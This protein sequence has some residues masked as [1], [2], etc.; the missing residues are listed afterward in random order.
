VRTIWILAWA[1][2]AALGTTTCK[3][4]E[5]ANAMA[6]AELITDLTDSLP[7]GIHVRDAVSVLEERELTHRIYSPNRCEVYA[8][9]SANPDASAG[10]VC[11]FGQ[12]PVGQPV[13][14][15]QTFVAYRLFFSTGERLVDRSIRVMDIDPN[16]GRILRRYPPR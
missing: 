10:G 1:A 13:H 7:I 12:D 16:H 2:L 5:N 4:I 3:S 15:V 6:A 14:H 9:E 8:A 11:I